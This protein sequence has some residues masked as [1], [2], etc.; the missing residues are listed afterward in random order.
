LAGLPLFVIGAARSGTNLV[1]ALLSAHPSIELRNEPE[2]FLS[3]IRAGVDAGDVVARG[4]RVRLLLELSRTG[5]THQHIGSLPPATI[6][7]F[8]TTGR[9]LGLRETYELL[10]PRPD[11]L[12]WGEKSLS[13]AYLMHEIGA[14]YPDAVFVHVVRDPRATTWSWLALHYLEDEGEAL[15]LD[16][17][18]VGAVAYSAMRWASWTD[19]IDCSSET[20]PDASVTRVRFEELVDEP[21]RVLQRVCTWLDVEFD[22]RMPDPERRSRDPVLETRRHAHRRLSEPIDPARA[23]AGDRLPAWA[24]AVVERYAGEGMARHG[25]RPRNEELPGREQQKLLTALDFLEPILRKRLARDA[26]RSGAA[27][28]PGEARRSEA[29]EARP[30]TKVDSLGALAATVI[31]RRGVGADSQS[32]VDALRAFAAA[33]IGELEDARAAR[34]RAQRRLATANARLKALQGQTKERPKEKRKRS[35]KGDRRHEEAEL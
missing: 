10:L 20:L 28:G 34:V 3:L 13:N 15:E 14:L 27:E 32:E 1:R 35:R 18:A 11:H 19:A 12:V 29:A 33:A 17:D 6:E 9:E 16:R 21:A 23:D 2:L 25:Y 5:L 8:L 4:D 22:E 24:A 7:E 31:R 30:T 26:A